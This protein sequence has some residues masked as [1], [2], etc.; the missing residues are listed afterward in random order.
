MSRAKVVASDANLR[1]K[2]F[3]IDTPQA[4]LVLKSRT[5]V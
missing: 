5:A 1:L 3:A 4:L 2:I